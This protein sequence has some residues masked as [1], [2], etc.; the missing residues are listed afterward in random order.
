LPT[1]LVTVNYRY[2][3]SYKINDVTPRLVD[4]E[5]PTVVRMVE[6]H[7]LLAFVS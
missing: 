3:A 1:G 7:L 2:E 4:V 5:R 6:L